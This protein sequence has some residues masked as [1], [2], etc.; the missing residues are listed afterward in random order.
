MIRHTSI[1]S[2]FLLFSALPSFAA[3]NANTIGI[4]AGSNNL[5]STSQRVLGSNIT[6]TEGSDSVVAAEYM[7]T[8]S[9]GYRF[10]GEIISFS[11]NYTSGSR[12][13]IDT[14][15]ILFN[16]DK[17]WDAT[18]WLKPYIGVGIGAVSIDVS[19]PIVGSAGGVAFAARAG[20]DFTFSSNV[21]LVV[22]YKILSGKP[23]DANSETI[24]VSGSGAYAGVNIY[25]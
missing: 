21:G 22:E 25:F 11:N 19:G 4:K 14:L 1:A 18:S 10:G 24:D 15:Y 9:G 17:R 20:I 16:A 12:G 2:L 5:S 23:D 8:I 6:L 13:T 3:E 7:R